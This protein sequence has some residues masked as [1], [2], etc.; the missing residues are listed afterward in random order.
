MS[1][2]AKKQVQRRWILEVWGRGNLALTDELVSPTYLFS[3]PG[4][5]EVPGPEGIKQ[6]ISMYRTAFPDLTSKIDEQIAEG[7]VVVSHGTTTGTHQGPLGEI[8][9]TGKAIRAHGSTFLGL[10]VTGSP[11]TSR[12]TT[13]LV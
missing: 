7:D 5:G 9:A 3:A 11:V 10:T 2:E 4:I 6:L 8:A 13:R 1:H 12:S